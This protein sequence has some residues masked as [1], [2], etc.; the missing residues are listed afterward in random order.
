MKICKITSLLFL[1][2]FIL[3]SGC[4][5]LRFL[6][7]GEENLRKK[8][9]IEWNAK[10]QKDWGKVYDLAVEEYKKK[11]N[12][13]TF[14]QGANLNVT[15]FEIKELKIIEPKS[16]ALATVNYTIN[17]MGFEFNMTARE[18]WMMEDNAWRLNLLPTL[19]MM[20]LFPTTKSD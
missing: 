15:G 11:V 7:E 20:M 8:V 10:I 6:P 13:V 18:E 17:P 1:A 19:N 16:K 14:M 4:A 2:V 12:R 3:S 5:H 9:C